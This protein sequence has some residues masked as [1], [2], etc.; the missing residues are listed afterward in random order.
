[1]GLSHVL[2]CVVLYKEGRCAILST[3]GFPLA[4]HSF[5]IG[6]PNAA[7]ANTQH[8]ASQRTKWAF[9]ISFFF[10]RNSVYHFYS[11]SRSYWDSFV[12]Q[13]KR[14][15]WN[16]FHVCLSGTEFEYKKA[17]SDH[18]ASL[19]SSIFFLVIEPSIIMNVY[20][21]QF[22]PLHHLILSVRTV[23]MMDV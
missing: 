21:L 13:A 11:C 15:N 1:M 4:A 17:A 14:R 23:S 2:P 5:W 3:L 8:N 22:Y 9:I 16:L 18:N 6:F 7:H 10:T 12:L 20:Y 19:H